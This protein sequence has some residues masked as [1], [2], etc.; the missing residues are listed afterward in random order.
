M[1]RIGRIMTETSETTDLTARQ[2]W[3]KSPPGEMRRNDL[4]SRI[5]EIR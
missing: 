4:I 5:L 2:R 1:M 3:L